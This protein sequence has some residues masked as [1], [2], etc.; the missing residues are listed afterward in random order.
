MKVFL[1]GGTGT[2][3]SAL[4]GPLL[5]TG[6]SIT[7]LIRARDDQHL[8]QRLSEL[9]TFTSQAY[10]EL[11]RSLWDTHVSGFRGDV[12]LDNSGLHEGALSQL[13]SSITHI[14]HCAASVKLNMS[15]TQAERACLIPTLNILKLAKTWHHSG[16]L[17]KVEYV[18]TVG[19]LGRGGP[20]LT[21]DFLFSDRRFHNTYESTK[22]ACEVHVHKAI[23]EGLPITVHRPSMVIGDSKTGH[24]KSFQVFYHLAEF[25]TGQKTWGVLP[26]IDDFKLDLVPNDYVANTII[27]SCGQLQWVGKVLHLC[28]G[29]QHSV[30]LGQLRNLIASSWQ[31]AGIDLP[32]IRRINTTAFIAATKLMTLLSPPELR[33]K[34]QTL[35]YFLDYLGEKQSFSNSH[36]LQLLS[37]VDQSFPPPNEF[38]RH[39]LRYYLQQHNR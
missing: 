37:A 21:E 36:T 15:V 17:K 35:P 39:S 8:T 18:S 2:L 22:A 27:S 24:V 33:K 23:V 13:Q 4:I 29:S 16:V 11:D 3:G 30:T 20:I 5:K 7:L 6:A 34:L 26:N 38:I 25:L 9:K 32:V 28:A 31:S 10:P 19:V 1:T 12:E 14:I